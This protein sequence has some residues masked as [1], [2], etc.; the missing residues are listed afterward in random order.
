MWKDEVM[1][2]RTLLK[3]MGL[4][5]TASVLATR[6]TGIPPGLAKMTPDDMQDLDRLADRYQALYAS[7][8]PAV[9]MTPVVACPKETF[10][11]QAPRLTTRYGRRTRSLQDSLAGVEMALDS[12][13]GPRLPAASSRSGNLTTV[14]KPS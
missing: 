3:L 9:L 1:Q 5:T 8:A 7:T 14:A 6:L 12:R 11:E 4:A 13:A 2:R 10:A